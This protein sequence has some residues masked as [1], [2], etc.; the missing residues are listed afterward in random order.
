VTR[1][2]DQ[3]HAAPAL[4]RRLVPLLAGALLACAGLAWSQQAPA[5]N[6]AGPAWSTLTPAQQH[7]LSPLQRDWNSIDAP[8]RRKWIEISERFGGLPPAEQARVQSRMAEW[9]KLTPKERAEARLNFKEAQQVA[10]QDRKS[11]WE[12]YKALPPDQRKQL[13]ERAEQKA[14]GPKAGREADGDAP[15]AKSSIVPNTAYAARPKAVAPT[16]A[17]AQPGATTNLISKRPTPPAHQQT[18][19][20][21]IATAPGLVD[22]TTLLPKRGPQAAATRAVPASAP[23]AGKPHR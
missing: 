7:A 18:G 22:S 5:G 8:R 6:G 9:A 15:E 3:D 17:Q 16:V 4:R 11:Q 14:P 2:L 12:A 1:R 13:A 19:L 10:P 23:A 20:P 21:K